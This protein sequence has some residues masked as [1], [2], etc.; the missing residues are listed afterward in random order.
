MSARFQNIAKPCSLT[1]LALSLSPSPQDRYLRSVA[2]FRNL[3]E[4]TRRDMESARDF[5]ISRFAKDLVDSVDNLDRALTTV[6]DDA[7]GDAANKHL[8]DLHGGLKM[9]EQILMKTLSNH[10]LVRFDP[11]VA[12]EGKEVGEKFDPNKHD[13]TFMA[14]VEDKED[15]TV[16]QTVQKGYMLN[17]RVIRVST[18]KQ[19]YG[20]V[21]AN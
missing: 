13:A 12:E 8:K 11:S 3:Q 2:D 5:A 20:T 16:F 6:P 21:C 17:G 1:H 4:R 7:L 19:I 14:K 9:T 18:S 10:G 15:G